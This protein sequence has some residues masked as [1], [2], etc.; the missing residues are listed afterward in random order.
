MKVN[1]RTFLGAVATTALSASLPVKLEGKIKN[2]NFTKDDRYDP[3]IEID[4]EA[5]KFNV[6]QLHDLSGKSP[7][8][9]VVKNNAYGLGLENTAKI[10]DELPEIVGFA[11]LKTDD[12]LSLRKSGIKKPILMMGMT[13][14]EALYDLV[15][16][17]I[18]PGIYQKDSRKMLEAATKKL[19][20]SI[21]VHLYIDTGMS[22]MG[23]PYHDAL[24]W[25]S[26]ISA[27]KTITVVGSFMSFTEDP[28]FDKEQLNRFLQLAKNATSAGANMGKLHA[29]SSNG[30]Y[31]LPE[32]RLDMVRPGIGIYGAYPTYPG[33]EKK[34]KPLK[35]AYRLCA[36]VVRVEKM[37]KGDSVSYGRNF[38]ADKPTWIATLPVG[39]ADGYLRKAVMG[40]KIMIGDKLYPVIGA[41]S[42]S[43]TIV[44]VGSEK[45]VNIGDKAILVGPDHPEINPSYISEKLGVSVYDILM[46]MSAR[47]PKMLF[48]PI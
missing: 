38:I 48:E 32:A 5:L 13:T 31:H 16:N 28:D 42:A 40:A 6:K 43:H 39:H 33:M 29:A 20:K 46:H 41:V 3:W 12:C 22:R 35:V 17:D 36:R 23:I 15:Q 19:G 47:L 26:D 37:R 2:I 18:Q 34:I 8:L 7:I 25:I 21:K 9:A 14:E 44:E 45:S 1:R 10:L 11:D 30:I 24:P 27:S 4:P